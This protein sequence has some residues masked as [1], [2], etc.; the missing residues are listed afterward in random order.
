MFLVNMKLDVN[1]QNNLADQRPD[2]VRAL[3]RKYQQWMEEV[4]TA[5]PPKQ[6]A[7]TPK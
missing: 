6:T 3:K 1:E 2:V 7:Q 4:A 5:H